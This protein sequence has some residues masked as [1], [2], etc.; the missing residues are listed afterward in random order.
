MILL[1]L[2][3][4]N[5]MRKQYFISVLLVVLTLSWVEAQENTI[6]FKS[7]L[8]EG[9][10]NNYNIKLQ[11]LSLEKADYTLL[12]A[13]GG[14]NAFLNTDLTY[15]SGINPSLDN[16]GTKSWQTEFVIPTRLGVNFYSGFRLER[17]INFDPTGNTPFNTSGA[18]AGLKIPLL[19]GLGKSSLLNTDILVSETNKSAFDM[20]LSNEILTYF[21]KLLINY[22]TL[23]QSIEELNISKNILFE[24]EKYRND[25]KALIEKDQ[26]PLSEESRAN[27]LYIQNLQQLNMSQ[28]QATQVYF[29]TKTLLGVDNFEKT[30]SLPS[31]SDAFPNPMKKDI[32]SFVDL[33]IQ[34]VD[35][36]IKLTPQYKS[37]ELRVQEEELLLKQARNQKQNPLDLDILLSSFGSNENSRFNLN[38]TFNGLPGTSLLITLTHNLPVRNQQRRGAYLEQLTE[39]NISKTNLSQYLYENT[40]NTKLKLDLLKQKVEMFDEALTLS[41]LMEKNYQDELAKFQLGSATQTDVIVVLE[42]YFDALKSVNN[43]KYDVWKSYIEIKFLLGDLPKSEGEL[44]SFYLI[45]LFDQI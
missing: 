39:F 28:M 7:I 11:Q 5:M 37:I 27:S 6:S 19:N 22:L 10:E 24:S 14:L 26:I 44:N 31:L 12:K 8:S 42:D 23:K 29:N 35:S 41:N 40:V 9:F 2:K 30:D 18:F 38:S 15:G 20:E 43:L 1:K 4:L 21:S 36:L 3:Y 32:Y 17:T 25:I 13:R 34:R 16:D 45:G 33:N